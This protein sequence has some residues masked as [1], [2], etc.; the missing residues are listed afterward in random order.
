M[1]VK[2]LLG[3]AALGSLYGGYR[4]VEWVQHRRAL[5]DPNQCPGARPNCPS[6][7]GKT[8]NPTGG[9]PIAG[10]ASAVDYPWCHRVEVG[11]SAGS[12]AAEVTGDASR[13]KELL[14]ANTHKPTAIT[15]QGEVNFTSLCVGERLSIPSSW[16][17]WID[18]TGASRGNKTPFPPF[19]AMGNY[20]PLAGDK[21]SL[22]VAPGVTGFRPG[23]G[24][25]QRKRWAHG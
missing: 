19:D 21:G 6:V 4:L 13:Y 7:A 18:Q 12:I 17:P 3:A 15:S 10:Q 14:A 25:G 23:S 11:Q 16:N 8:P 22:A 24:L 20:P 5:S 9:A 2:I 1:I